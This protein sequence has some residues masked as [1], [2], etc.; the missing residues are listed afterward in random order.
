MSSTKHFKGVWLFLGLTLVFSA[1]FWLLILFLQGSR[2]YVT[3]L[4]WS[5]GVAALITCKMTGRPIAALGWRWGE[6]RRQVQSYLI[7]FGYA[8]AAYL[9][10]WLTGLGGFYNHDAVAGIAAAYGWQGLP[11]G[12]VI[13][14]YVF[15]IGGAGMAGYVSTALGEEI[16]WRGYLVPVLAERWSFVRLSLVSGL[17]WAIWHYPLILFGGYNGG[18]NVFFALTCFTVMVVGIS[19]AMAWLRLRS[20][21][22]WTAAIFHAAHNLY[23]QGVFTPLT[24]DTGGTAYFIDEFGVVL[25]IATI[26]VAFYVWRLHVKEP[27][28]AT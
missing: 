7:P 6:T 18:L 16:G 13:V 4:M 25:P 28:A 22:L 9:V 3:G 27:V 2:L 10:V 24:R 20:G 23:I 21:S 1:I 5:P 19:F 14:C 12:A 17:I 26:L 15:L 11:D 8:L